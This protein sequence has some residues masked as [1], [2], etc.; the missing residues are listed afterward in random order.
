[1]SLL[2]RFFCVYLVSILP[3]PLHTC[4]LYGLVSAAAVPSLTPLFSCSVFT[5]SSVEHCVCFYARSGSSS[6]FICIFSVISACFIMVIVNSSFLSLLYDVI[7][8]SERGFNKTGFR[9]CPFYGKNKYFKV[10]QWFCPDCLVLL[11][12]A[13][14]HSWKGMLSRAPLW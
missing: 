13:D 12:V 7:C 11:Q 5:P 9:L 6:L 4:S 2:V 1:M 14:S 8:Q 3:R 10:L